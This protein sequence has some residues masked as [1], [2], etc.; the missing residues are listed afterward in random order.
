MAI[1]RVGLIRVV[2]GLGHDQ[3]QAH[4]RILERK[5]P[6][7]SVITE[8]IDGFPNGL[9]SEE[10]E[11]QAVPEILRAARKL[12]PFVDVIAVSCAADPGIPELRR[13]VTA[14]VVGA[15]SC[16]GLVGRALGTKIGI[17]TISSY[18]PKAVVE[19]LCGCPIAWRQVDGVHRT[20][21]LFN[22]MDALT[23]AAKAL[24]AD[25]CRAIALACTG[26]STIGAAEVL[27]KQLQT[28]ILD[29]VEA[30][31]ACIVCISLNKGVVKSGGRRL[32]EQESEHV[33]FLA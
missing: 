9:Y 2:S 4:A 29:P 23:R 33:A 20:T 13:V 21:D 17:L 1:V 3:M 11:D 30:M 12:S 15:G 24:F 31:G 5:Y 7:L 19:S 14:P 26:F 28:V 18:V 32:K 27:R 6:F 25:G 16:L 22:A 10:M 8:A